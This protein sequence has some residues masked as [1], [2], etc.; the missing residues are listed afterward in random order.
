MSSA[1]RRNSPS[2]DAV[3]RDL[4]WTLFRAEYQQREAVPSPAPRMAGPVAAGSTN[5]TLRRDGTFPQDAGLAGLD[6]TVSVPHI[7]VNSKLLA[8]IRPLFLQIGYS[9]GY[10]T[11]CSRY[12]GDL[13]QF[14]I[15]SRTRSYVESS[16]HTR[17]SRTAV[18]TL[19]VVGS[20]RHVLQLG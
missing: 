7:L 5:L 17:T 6:V 9:T 12:L 2:E 8:L 15:Q 16:C 18:A 10:W 20:G 13:P 4:C 14:G 3:N 19:L 11:P 1:G